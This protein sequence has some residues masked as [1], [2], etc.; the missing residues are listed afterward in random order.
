MCRAQHDVATRWPPARPLALGTTRTSP[1]RSRFAQ[2]TVAVSID[3]PVAL[4][5]LT[6]L[7]QPYASARYLRG[8]YTRPTG[9]CV[10]VL[11]RLVHAGLSALMPHALVVRA[12]ALVRVLSSR[13]LMRMRIFCSPAIRRVSSCAPA[14]RSVAALFARAFSYASRVLVSSSRSCKQTKSWKRCLKGRTSI[15]W[16]ARARKRCRIAQDLARMPPVDHENRPSS[17][18]RP[19]YAECERSQDRPV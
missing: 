2:P 10:R 5:M 11:S 14:E 18:L 15:T 8:S 7:S 13:A 9:A 1:A 17:G 4:R 16:R 19:P 3:A 12:E 6:E